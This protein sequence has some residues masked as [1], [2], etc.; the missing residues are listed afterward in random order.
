M[1]EVTHPVLRM[2][3]EKPWPGS[4]SQIGISYPFKREDTINPETN[5]SG[6]HINPH[7]VVGPRRSYHR[8]GGPIRDY[9][10]HIRTPGMTKVTHLQTSMAV[11][12]N[13]DSYSCVNSQEVRV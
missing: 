10:K 13:R 4:R 5:F 3:K 2:V 9:L 12:S 11:G 7:L 1:I 8:E 6:Q